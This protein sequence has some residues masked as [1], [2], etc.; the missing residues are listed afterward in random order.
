MV[1]TYKKFQLPT[2]PMETLYYST[3]LSNLV[4]LDKH[5]APAPETFAAMLIFTIECIFEQLDGMDV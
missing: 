2:S 3:L 4:K 1:L 5:R